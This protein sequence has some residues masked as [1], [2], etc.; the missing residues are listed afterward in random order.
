MVVGW[1]GFHTP[2]VNGMMAMAVNNSVATE[3]LVPQMEWPRKLSA[4]DAGLGLMVK[5]LVNILG[6]GQEMV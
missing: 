6:M 2:V 1:C 3:L 4:A 5:V